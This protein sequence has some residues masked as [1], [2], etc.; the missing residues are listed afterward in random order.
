M[1]SIDKKIQDYL[2]EA[3]DRMRDDLATEEDKNDN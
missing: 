1:Y 2:D 3:W